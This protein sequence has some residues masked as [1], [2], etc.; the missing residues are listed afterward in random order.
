M[1]TMTVLADPVRRQVV[2]LLAE[3]ERSAGEI[4]DQFDISQPSVSRHL[5]VLREAG[6]VNARV[7]ANRRIYSLNPRP[8]EEVE[9]WAAKHL[10]QWHR[11]FD[12]LGAHLD[13]MEAAE[14]DAKKK[15]GT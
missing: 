4:V 6:L 11:A 3:R 9:E 8:L 15:R 10:A 7:D 14:L 2:E 1:D 12:R 13:Q 5:K